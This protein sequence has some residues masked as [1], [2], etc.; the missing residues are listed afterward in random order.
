MFEMFK[1]TETQ[2]SNT[3]REAICRRLAAIEVNGRLQ[4]LHL[5]SSPESESVHETKAKKQKISKFN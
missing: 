1:Q 5:R 2:I 3:Y 4:T